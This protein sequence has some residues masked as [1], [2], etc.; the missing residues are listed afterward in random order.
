ML[1]P[2]RHLAE[3]VSYRATRERHARDDAAGARRARAPSGR[4][5]RGGRARVARASPGYRLSFEGVSLYVDPYVSRVPLSAL[6]RG[7]T[8]LPDARARSTASSGRT[9]ARWRGCSSATHTSTTRSTRPRSPAALSV[10]GVRIGLARPPDGAPRARR[11]ARSRSSPTASTSSVRSGS[12]SRRASTR[13][14][15]SAS[16]CRWTA[17]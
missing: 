6:L 5:A 3:I 12:R 11:P 10:Q 8:A 1:T 14:C 16:P 9:A 15:C 4:A 7:H 17:S 2:L 13:S